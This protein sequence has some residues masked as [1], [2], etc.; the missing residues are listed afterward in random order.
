[1]DNTAKTLMF[2]SIKMMGTLD[3]CEVLSYI[4]EDLTL[5]QYRD[6]EGFLQYVNDNKLSFGHGNFDEVYN[7]YKKSK[8]NTRKDL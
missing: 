8:N 6:I 3:P 4:E 1:M 5:K 2:R 7:Q